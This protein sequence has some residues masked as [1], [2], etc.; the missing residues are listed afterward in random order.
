MSGTNKFIKEGK[1][2]YTKGAST[3][4]KLVFAFHGLGDSIPRFFSLLP[5]EKDV[6]YIALQAPEPWHIGFGI[7]VNYQWCDIGS[8]W[9]PNEEKVKA[10]LYK[11]TPS[12]LDWI[13]TV[14]AK[15]NVSYDN[16]FVAGFSLGALLSGCLLTTSSHL[17]NAILISGAIDPD[18]TQSQSGKTVLSIYVNP[19]TIV[20]YEKTKEGEKK[21]KDLGAHVQSL[22][23]EDMP[24]YE[25]NRLGK[26]LTHMKACYNIETREKIRD[27]ITKA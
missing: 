8:L 11:I 20:P 25:W 2:V 6:L 13:E 24:S 5:D 27:F 17:K 7:K 3:P 1:V 26:M 19:D 21:L 23:L 16:V 18:L 15:H 9:T 10:G 22:A 14:R 12:I 4:K